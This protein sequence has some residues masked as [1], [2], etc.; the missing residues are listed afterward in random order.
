MNLSKLYI[1]FI[2]I[3]IFVIIFIFINK[4]IENY[5]NT[6]IQCKTPCK[7]GGTC[8]LNIG[9]CK[10]IGNFT[11]NDCSKCKPFFYGVN[12]DQK[13]CTIDS[14]CFNGQKCNNGTCIYN[15]D[16][17]CESICNYKKCGGYDG[18]NNLCN[19]KLIINNPSDFIWRLENSFNKVSFDYNSLTFVNYIVVPVAN[20]TPAPYEKILATYILKSNNGGTDINF[21]SDTYGGSFIRIL[22]DT[23]IDN[24]VTLLENSIFNLNNENIYVSINK[25]NFNFSIRPINCSNDCLTFINDDNNCG[26]CGNKCPSNTKCCGRKCIPIN[27]SETC[28][29]HD[30]YKSC[31]TNLINCGGDCVSTDLYNFDCSSKQTPPPISCTLFEKPFS[32]NWILYNGTQQ[33]FVL[34]LVQTGLLGQFSLNYKG[35]KA[36]T[37]QHDL[38]NKYTRV[39]MRLVYTDPTFNFITLNASTD[40]INFDYDQSQK[41]Y[42]LFNNNSGFPNKS[43]I[44]ESCDC[45]KDTACPKPL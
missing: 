45:F 7:N 39:Q 8:D 27:L 26:K 2:I 28:N 41:V 21:E 43:I 25:D 17:S 13:K 42:F 40:Q 16:N 23:K 6:I 22:L 18:C 3:I 9:N 35:V 34:Q 31:G 29:I 44:L 19:I 20:T 15:N 24:S 4:Y 1:I 33:K 11:S 5:N 32:V 14:D 12:C 37:F 30:C 36:F 10:C 38:V